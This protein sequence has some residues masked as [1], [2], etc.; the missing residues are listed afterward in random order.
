MFEQSD[1]G[2]S[3]N[4]KIKMSSFGDGSS[5]RIV[6]KTPAIDEDEMAVGNRST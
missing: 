2:T 4:V 3:Q 1:G 5:V 6:E